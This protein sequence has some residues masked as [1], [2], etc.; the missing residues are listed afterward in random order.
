MQTTAP[1]RCA[2]AASIWLVTLACLPGGAHAADRVMVG[3]L[4]CSLSERSGLVFGAGE[5]VTCIFQAPG[6]SPERYLGLID[7]AEGTL[8]TKPNA[9][10]S[11]TVEAAPGSIGPAALEGDYRGNGTAA[12]LSGGADD[13]IALR[14]ASI[15]GQSAV[16]LAAGVSLLKLKAE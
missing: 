16:N 10:L 11:W 13:A 3:L 1:I 8:A 12:N 9:A 7:M 15:L 2:A 4:D 6:A 5:A 14:P